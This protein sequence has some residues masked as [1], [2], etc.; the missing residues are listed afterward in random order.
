LAPSSTPNGEIGR[1][2][3]PPAAVS[4]LRDPGTLIR[5]F[6][7]GHPARRQLYRTA[8]Q[9]GGAAAQQEWAQAQAD[10][11]CKQAAVAHETAQQSADPSRTGSLPVYYGL[12]A[13]TVAV[14]A[15]SCYLAA[16]VFGGDQLSTVFVA[17]LLLAGLAGCVLALD[18]AS[19]RKAHTAWRWIVGLLAGFILALGILRFAFLLTVNGSLLNALLGA[20]LLTVATAGLVALG[21]WGLRE[22]EPVEMYRQHRHLKKAWR[23]AA[24]ARRAARHAARE[25]DKQ[26]QAYTDEMQPWLVETQPH[27]TA[28]EVKETVRAVAHDLRKPAVSAPHSLAE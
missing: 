18:V 17:L 13:A 1:Q 7:A 14:D 12:A 25:R 5:D 20:G 21:Y 6:H 8:I 23:N 22:A 27:L 26:V 3:V 11:D 4:R 28:D 15:T 10:T 9:A 24:K 19:S 16:Q 2:E